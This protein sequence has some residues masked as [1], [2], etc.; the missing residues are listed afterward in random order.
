MECRLF[1]FPHAQ[2]FYYSSQRF[3][4]TKCQSLNFC[5]AIV[6]LDIQ[7]VD[8]FFECVFV[9]NF[10]GFINTSMSDDFPEM[11]GNSSTTDVDKDNIIVSV[12]L[13]QLRDLP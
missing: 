4:V 10:D 3:A 11:L 6:C 13:Q 9:N 7:Q 12:N 5:D 1:N 8:T 2:Q